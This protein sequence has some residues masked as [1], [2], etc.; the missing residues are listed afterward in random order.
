ML[1]APKAGDRDWAEAALLTQAGT[2]PAAPQAAPAE[3]GRRMSPRWPFQPRPHSDSGWHWHRQARATRTPPAAR[4]RLGLGL[5]LGLGLVQWLVGSRAGPDQVP[6]R[7]SPTEI[8]GSWAR[9]RA[10][11][12]RASGR[13][14]RT[15][16]PP[17]A[18]HGRP[19]RK[20]ASA[21]Q[22]SRH[23]ACPNSQPTTPE[24][25]LAAK[26]PRQRAGFPAG[27]SCNGAN[28]LPAREV[29]CRLNCSIRKID[30]LQKGLLFHVNLRPPVC[31]DWNARYH[32][33]A[34]DATFVFPSGDA[35]KASLQRPNG[36][37]GV[38]GQHGP[39]LCWR[40][41]STCVCTHAWMHETWP[42]AAVLLP[43]R[44]RC[45]SCQTTNLSG[46]RLATQ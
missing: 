15:S 32:R 30:S 46:P 35:E 18:A 14:L 31:S 44:T 2:E 24:C 41:E 38:E 10:T 25:P 19:R 9:A 12:K 27:V 8:R 11:A 40:T 34:L 21:A 39:A 13:Q 20:L 26:V 45:S 28:R 5:G 4:L 36:L 22:V 42:T 16:E 43:R 33:L 3:P 7:G 6:A 29:A 17:Q 23:M 37:K 1:A